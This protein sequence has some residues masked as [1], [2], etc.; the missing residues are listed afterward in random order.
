M[1]DNR[2]KTQLSRGQ[3]ANAEPGRLYAEF[4]RQVAEEISQ[5]KRDVE[6]LKRS[7]D[8]FQLVERKSG[9]LVKLVD[10]YNYVT[11]TLGHAIPSSAELEK[12]LVWSR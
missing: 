3:P 8:V 9:S 7:Q 10:E 5:L 6:R 2:I 12:W 11:I 4:I 1:W